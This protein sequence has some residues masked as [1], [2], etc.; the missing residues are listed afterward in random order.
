ME[1]WGDWALTELRRSAELDRLCRLAEGAHRGGYPRTT[2]PLSDRSWE[3]LEAFVEEGAQ[4]NLD[5]RSR[6]WK[7]GRWHETTESGL[8]HVVAY[9]RGCKRVARSYLRADYLAPLV[10]ALVV[11]RSLPDGS[12]LELP[13]LPA[14][15]PAPTGPVASTCAAH[16]T[17]APWGAG[18]TAVRQAW[19]RHRPRE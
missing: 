17:G 15:G 9:V 2:G 18:A 1:D 3:E 12:Q 11:E 13:A 16:I 4:S 14:L 6:A 19:Y 10:H 8:S 5:G 7:E